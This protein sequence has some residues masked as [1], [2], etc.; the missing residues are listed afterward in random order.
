MKYVPLN[1]HILLEDVES[2]EKSVSVLVPDDYKIIKNFGI[3]RVV[4]FSVDC[5]T[6]FEAGEVVV[7]EENM[8]REVE[9]DTD[10][11]YYVI[12]ENLVV[13][14]GGVEEE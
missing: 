7:V 9:L 1:R 5:D 10:K 8:V 14:R 2:T 13:L 4:D 6:F 3:Y 11:K 12:T